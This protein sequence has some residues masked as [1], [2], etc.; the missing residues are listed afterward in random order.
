VYESVDTSLRIGNPADGPYVAQAVRK[1]GGWAEMAS[2]DEIVAAI[3]LLAATEGIWTET[4]GGTTLAV[5]RKL[6]EQGRIP[7][8]E[9]TV[10]C[11]TGNG[12]KTLEAVKDRIGEPVRIQATLGSFEERVYANVK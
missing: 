6:I 4:A 9:S 11:I 8:D 5:T 2:D 12:L 3:K 1:S 10:V 7:R